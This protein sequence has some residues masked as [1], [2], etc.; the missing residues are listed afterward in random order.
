[1][2]EFYDG[3]AA[4]DPLLQRNLGRIVKICKVP[5]LAKEIEAGQALAVADASI[6]AREIKKTFCGIKFCTVVNNNVNK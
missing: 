2:L 4:L 6:G 5:E 1:M 3:L